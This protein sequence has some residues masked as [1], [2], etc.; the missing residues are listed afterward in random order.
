MIRIYCMLLSCLI[1]HAIAYADTPVDLLFDEQDTVISATESHRALGQAPSIVTVIT[2]KQIRDMGAHTLIEALESVPGLNVSYPTDLA[3]GHTLT[4]RGLKSSE[5]EKTLLLI[6][7]HRVNNPYSGSWT[8]LFDEF[9]LDD[10]RRIEIIRGP[11]SALYGSNAMA[12]VIHIITRGAED[13]RGSEA[14]A[15]AGNHGYVNGHVTTGGMGDDASIML[16][17]NSSSTDGDRQEILRDAAGKSGVGNFWRR[18]QQGFISA[19]AGNWSLFAMHVNKRRGTVLDGTNLIDHASNVM[20]RQSIAALTWARDGDLWDVSIRTDADLFDLDPHWQ[21]FGGATIVR[22]AVK[23]LTLSE[24]GLLRYRGWQDHEWTFNINYDHIRQFDVRNFVNGADVS[25]LFNHNSNVTRQVFALAIQDEWSPL[26][27]LTVTAGVRMEHYSDVGSHASPRFALVWNAT[28]MLDVKLMYGHAFRAPN[29]V[30]LYSANNPVV[31]GNANVR[32]ESVNTYEF[33]TSLHKGVWHLDG[34]VYYSRYKNLITRIAPSPLTVNVGRE[35]LRGFEA[36][37]RVDIQKGLYGALSYTWQ[38]GSSNLT[39]ARLPDVPMQVIR[40]SGDA[41]LPLGTHLH[42]DAHWIG[43]QART[44][45]DP[46]PALASTWQVDLAIR[47]GNVSSGPSMSFVMNNVFNQKIFS[48]V[49][50]PI[51]SDIPL[52]DREWML[53]FAWVF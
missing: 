33:G 32:P 29:F 49:A 24:S 16:S 47:A 9:P 17:L 48:P 31:L 27:D 7:G 40:L 25:A 41:P 15:S 4:V 37:L 21:L 18:Q 43:S 28:D 23:N 3:A 13:F 8:F 39:A 20:V 46:R 14:G 50:T 26:S 38:T 22:P 53:D 52:H 11:G 34:N 30:E 36:E 42:M 5:A 44:A 6:N 1:F 35:T 19:S 10:V 2:E 51:M 45:A 12:A